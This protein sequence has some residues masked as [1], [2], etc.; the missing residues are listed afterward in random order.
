MRTCV[1]FEIE[2]TFVRSFLTGPGRGN[3]TLDALL[4]PSEHSLNAAAVK[5]AYQWLTWSIACSLGF[6]VVI[7][8]H[9]F[10]STS[11]QLAV[12]TW[13]TDW[14]SNLPNHVTDTLRNLR[15]RRGPFYLSLFIV[16]V[17]L[18]RCII[19]L[20]IRTWLSYYAA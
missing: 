11:E 3:V 9:L 1:D 10:V 20:S 19:A 4:P 14:L 2:V 18:V 16:T 7:F 15:P 13:I 12:L 17:I 6:I 5:Q 8:T